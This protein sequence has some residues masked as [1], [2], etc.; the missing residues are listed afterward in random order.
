[1][2]THPDL[3]M[4][5]V[6]FKRIGGGR[7]ESFEQPIGIEIRGHASKTFQGA[8]KSSMRVLPLP[9]LSDALLGKEVPVREF[10]GIECDKKRLLCKFRNSMHD[11]DEVPP[12]F[13]LRIPRQILRDILLGVEVTI[14]ERN[15]HKYGRKSG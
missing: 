8:P 6:S 14:L 11:G 13:C 5:E 4:C 15:T 9:V 3:D 7:E 12:R 1:M 10:P 2:R